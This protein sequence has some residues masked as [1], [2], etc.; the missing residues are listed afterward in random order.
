MPNP[1]SLETSIQIAAKPSTVFRFL[2]DPKLFQEWMGTGAVLGQTDLTVSYPGG[3]VAKGTIREVIPDQKLVFGWGYVSSKHG[4]AP[5][6]TTVTIELIPTSDGG[7]LV[8]LTHEN[9]DQAQQ[10]EHS[11]GWTYYLHQLSS[12]AETVAV[13]AVL[14]S[15]IATY[16]DAWNET[17]ADRRRELLLQCWEPDAAFRDAMGSAETLQ[18]LDGYIAGAHQFLPGFRLEAAGPHDFVRGFVRFPWIIRLPNGNVMSRGTNFGRVSATGKFQFV[19][20][21]WDA[22]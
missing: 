5:D 8:K 22:T 15:T 2:S 16:C 9:L 21:F 7:T 20:G 3:E 1:N 13:A 6:S 10:S 18:A 12:Q 11:K 4:L 17:I 14:P 19:T